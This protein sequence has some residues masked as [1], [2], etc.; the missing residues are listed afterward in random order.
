[1][2]YHISNKVCGVIINGRSCV[3][4]A[5]T[6]LLEKFNI[7]ITKFY[8]SYRLQWLSEYEKIN[9]NKYAFVLFFNWEIQ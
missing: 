2:R 3:N 6:T 8:R 1:M 5:S 9:D 7:N 4:V